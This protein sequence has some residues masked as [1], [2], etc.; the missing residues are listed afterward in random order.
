M[1]RAFLY[2]LVTAAA[3]AS[4]TMT[5]TPPDPS[6]LDE[7]P[8]ID[9]TIKGQPF[10][11]WVADSFAEQDDGLKRITADQMAPLP[12]GTER[13]MLFVFDHSVR[14]SFW[15]KDTIIPLDIA[16]IANDGAVV[17]VYTMVPLDDRHNAYPPSAP[18]RYAIEVMAKRL[19]ELGLKPGDVLA[20][21]AAV[22]KGIG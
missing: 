16:Y 1:S 5:C 2:V 4:G 6:R 18:Y 14:T 12:D 7:L 22:L 19:T 11:L 9:L 8:T 20:I 21:P 10:R 3:T 17:S 13:G 15:M